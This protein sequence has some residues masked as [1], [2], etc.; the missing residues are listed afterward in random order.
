MEEFEKNLKGNN[1]KLEY[2]RKVQNGE[3]HPRTKL[4]KNS[5]NQEPDAKVYYYPDQDKVLFSE[6][7]VKKM[8]LDKYGENIP[9]ID[10]ELTIFNNYLFD[11]WGYYLNAEGLALYGHLKRFAYGSKDW[12]F[13]N[14]ELI[15]MKMDKTRPTIHNFMDI[16]ERYGFSFKLSVINH[17]RLGQE[18]SPV[19]KLRKKIPLLTEKLIYGDPT[20]EIP[21]D[22]PAHIKKALKKEKTGL[23]KRLQ[24]EHEKYVATMINNN[25]KVEL[26]KDINFEEIY[27]SWIQYGKIIK[28]KEKII[29]ANQKDIVVTKDYAALVKT[30]NDVEKTILNNLLTFIEKKVSKPSF[31]TWFQN[32]IVKKNLTDIIIYS[33]SQFNKDWLEE[34]YDSIIREA[35]V[36]LDIEYE[37]VAYEII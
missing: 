12:C 10:G 26:E 27:Q 5:S 1:D 22:A 25:E 4:I 3:V 37:N 18:E 11:F 13:P 6:E 19:F 16:L 7:E 35:L 15:S 32:I 36:N 28:S 23:P 17:S 20:I 29:K 33:N 30:V 8:S 9:Y 2:Y 24:K 31:D 21:E 34:K 14:F